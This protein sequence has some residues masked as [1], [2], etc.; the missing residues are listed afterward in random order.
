MTLLRSPRIWVL[1]FTCGLALGCQ[2]VHVGSDDAGSGGDG[3]TPEQCGPVTCDPGLVCCNES[4]GICTVPSAGCIAIACTTT[5]FSNFECGPGQYCASGTC[6]GEGTCVPVAEECPAVYAP[7]CGCDGSTYGNTCSAGR[8]GANVAHQGE[9]VSDPRC[10]P[11]DARGVGDCAAIVGVIWDGRRCTMIGGCSCEGSDC[12]SVYATTLECENAQSGCRSCVA[13]DARGNGPCDAIVGIFWNGTSC[14]TES[15]C[16]CVGSDCDAGFSDPGDCAAGQR[17]C[18]PPVGC[19]TNAE[20][21]T[22]ELCAHPRGQCTAVGTC[23]P[24]PP[25]LPCVDPVFQPVCGCDGATHG[26]EEAAH[27]AGVSVAYDGACGDACAAQDV[28]AEGP[29]ALFLGIYWNGMACVGFSGCSCVGTDCSRVTPDMESCTSAHVG[30][31]RMPGGDC[32]GFVGFPCRPDEWCDYADG[33]MCGAADALGR[34]QP[35]PDAC[36][37]ELA[38][39]CGCDGTIHDNECF[40]QMAGFDLWPTLGSCPAPPPGG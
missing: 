28:A 1:L 18:V 25:E 37:F 27:Q 34:C 13:Q 17:H 16:S 30:C 14:V 7:V 4:C 32:G 36:P 23:E 20:C 24:L 22:G 35:R 39:V 33:D 11:M 12:A 9:C 3:A 21:G 10:A 29:C 38:P 31:D 19:I 15:G 40:A 2:R 8:V 5:C 26:C 6:G